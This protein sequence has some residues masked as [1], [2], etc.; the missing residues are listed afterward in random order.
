MLIYFYLSHL[1]LSGPEHRLILI[2]T[3]ADILLSRLDC[4]PDLDSCSV[5]AQ[6]EVMPCVVHYTVGAQRDQALLA[7]VP[8]LL[9][10]MIFTVLSQY[11]KVFV[12]NLSYLF[13]LRLSLLLLYVSYLI[14]SGFVID[15][16][17][18]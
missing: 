1:L 11:V 12:S 10:W 2:C 14:I 13:Q 7:V 17:V 18:R 6:H 5:V 9:L 8:D 3:L 16:V 4:L 15:V